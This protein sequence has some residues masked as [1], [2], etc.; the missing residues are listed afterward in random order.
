VDL[1]GPAVGV[2]LDACRGDRVPALLFVGPEGSGKEHTA[3][4]FARRIC[5]ASTPPCELGAS[6]CESCRLAASL[7][8][9]SI[10]LVYPTPSQGAGEQPGDDE[11][12]VGKILDSKREDLF[13][14]FEFSK[15]ASIRI[16]RARAIIQRA[17]TKPLYGAHTVFVIHRADLMREEAQNALLKLVEEPPVHCVLV[18]VA[19]NPD[20]IL[21]TIR[22]RCQRVRFS[23]LRQERLEA[24]LTGYYGMPPGA[25]SKIAEHARG[26]IQRA[27]VIMDEHDDTD[28]ESVFAILSQLRDAPRSW[29][30]Q[31]A[32]ALGRGRSRDGV[33]K[34]LQ[35]FA[36]AFRDVMAGEEKLLVNRDRATAV[37]AQ[38]A[39]WNRKNL[40][41]VVDRIVVTRDQ[42]LRRNLNVD[43]ALV[44]LLL[45][46]QRLGC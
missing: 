26:S 36:T 30:I 42:I 21:F 35:E 11:I 8:H 15:K 40:P 17:N 33:A 1:R 34:V 13:E 38:S 24:L 19:E 25:A 29:V 7:E 22:S 3:I 46:I 6:L 2:F 10:Y 44:S 37:L 9:P 23:P 45:D 16:A 31:S 32:L 41:G 28:R 39:T 18:F 43:A 12:E 14:N 27:R 4:D 20:A 5:C